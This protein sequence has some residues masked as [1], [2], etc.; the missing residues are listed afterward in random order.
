MGVN[1]D[2]AKVRGEYGL[3]IKQPKTQR[4]YRVPPLS[5]ALVKECRKWKYFG[6]SPNTLGNKFR[7]LRDQCGVPIRFHMLRHFYCSTL[8]D[9]GLDLMTILSYGGWENIEMV[10]KIYAYKMKNKKKD[11][12]VISIYTKFISHIPA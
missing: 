10:T 4:G 3:E 9:E 6:M 11:E 8:I 7:K 2:K 12:K 5:P 1:I